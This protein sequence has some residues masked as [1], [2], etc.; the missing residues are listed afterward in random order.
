M[1]RVTAKKNHYNLKS[2]VILSSMF[3]PSKYVFF[4]YLHIRDTKFDGNVFAN[5]L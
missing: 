3:F 2:L 4:F 5:L 1:K